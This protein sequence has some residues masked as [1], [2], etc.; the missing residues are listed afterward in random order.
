MIADDIL[1]ALPEMRAHAESLML[2]AC[3]AERPGPPIFNPATG[4]DE[5]SLTL[6]YEGRCKVQTYEGHETTREAGG[7]LVTEQRYSVH[8]PMAAFAPKV[9]DVITIISSPED[10]FLAGRTYRVVAPLHKT[11]TTARRL[12][13]EDVT[14]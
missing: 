2:D 3:R 12:G 13:V 4:V 14:P 9:G 10:P 6:L 8:V 7:A 5:P 11:L 1:A